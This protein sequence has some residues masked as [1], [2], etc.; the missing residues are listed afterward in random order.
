GFLRSLESLGTIGAF[1]EVNRQLQA[2]GPGAR[3]LITG[4][5]KGGALAP[6]A[7]L[8]LWAMNQTPSRVITFAGPRVGDRAFADIYNNA[9]IVHTRYE[10]QDDIVPHVPPRIGGLVDEL[11]QI[12]W[13]GDWF[14]DVRLADYESVG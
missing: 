11:K 4:H 6:L 5:S 10:F 2:A 3:L 14:A 13:L 9:Q 12:P 7:A 8:R 1:D